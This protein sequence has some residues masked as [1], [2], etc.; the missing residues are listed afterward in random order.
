MT[1]ISN[2]LTKRGD[3]ENLGDDSCW[4]DETSHDD[5]FLNMNTIAMI[6]FRT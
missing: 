3:S 5:Q 1:M 2:N 6:V 4:S